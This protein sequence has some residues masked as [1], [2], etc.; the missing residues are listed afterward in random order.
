MGTHAG[1]TLHTL[2]QGSLQRY[3]SYPSYEKSKAKRKVWPVSSG[4]LD[5]LFPVGCILAIL[6]VLALT[7]IGIYQVAKWILGA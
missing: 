6:L 1:E 5:W 7:F 2:Q 4:T 3:G